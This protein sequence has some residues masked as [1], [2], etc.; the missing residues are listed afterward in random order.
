[1]MNMEG[2]PT[3]FVLFIATIILVVTIWKNPSNNKDDE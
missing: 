2:F 3:K 1:M